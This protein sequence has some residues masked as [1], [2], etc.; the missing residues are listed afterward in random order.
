MFKFYLIFEFIFMNEM[1]AIFETLPTSQ[2]SSFKVFHFRCKRFPSMLHFHNEFE[3]VYIRKG[4]GIRY[5]GSNVSEFNAGDLILIGPGLTHYYKNEE[6]TSENKEDWAESL[7]I[8]FSI[9]SLGAGFFSLP[10]SSHIKQLLDLCEYGLQLEGKNKSLIIDLFSRIKTQS[11][12]EQLI[13]FLNILHLA[14]NSVIRTLVSGHVGGGKHDKMEEISRY[15]IENI[16]NPIILDEISKRF[17]MSKSNFCHF[18][19]RRTQR[20]CTDYINEL[21][22]SRACKL[23]IENRL[24]ITQIAFECG[25]NNISYFNNRFKKFMGVQPTEYKRL[26]LIQD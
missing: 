5:I 3:L 15:L 23:I 16:A 24:N 1:K 19:R 20:A 26:Y 18:F 2:P 10:E 8:H 4:K 11:G 6:I 21:R 12:M 25:F 14:S 13:S 7:V 22:I 9:D 17:G